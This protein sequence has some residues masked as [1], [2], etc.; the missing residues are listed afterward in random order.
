MAAQNSLAMAF[1]KGHGAVKD[2]QLGA[3][4]YHQSANQ[5]NTIGQYNCGVCY[6]YGTGVLQN[7]DEAQRR[8]RQAAAK[9]HVVA[10]TAAKSMQL[11]KEQASKNKFMHDL[12][13]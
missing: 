3:F 5:C 13:S 1:F 10:I 12:L 7:F 4:Y 9:G 11:Q 2:Q 8:F 6:Y